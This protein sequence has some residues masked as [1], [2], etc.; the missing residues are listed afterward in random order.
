M[1]KLEIL[2]IPAMLQASFK[3][4]ANRQSLVFAGE[5]NR[6]YAQLETE[7]KKA[8][9]QLEVLGVKKNGKV[10]ILSLNMPHWNMIVGSSGENIYSLHADFQAIS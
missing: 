2:T 8:A 4:F 3:D 5:E 1:G 6:T 10:A 9:L 7:V